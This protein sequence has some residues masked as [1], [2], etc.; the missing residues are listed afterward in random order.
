MPLV[1]HTLGRGGRCHLARAVA[2]TLDDIRLQPQRRHQPR[3]PGPV[4]FDAWAFDLALKPHKSVVTITPTI[5][6][7]VGVALPIARILD[8]GFG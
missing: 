7:V 5:S 8:L 3:R 4:G 2:G 6:H 1:T